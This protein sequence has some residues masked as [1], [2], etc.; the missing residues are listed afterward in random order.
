MSRNSG[1]AKVS[2]QKVPAQDVHT[3]CI[4][5]SSSPSSSDCSSCGG[6]LDVDGVA[7][8]SVELS[9]K[10]KKRKAEKCHSG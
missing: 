2:S 9:A 8:A 3:Q 10:A 7:V 5:T 1:S 4:W 6:L